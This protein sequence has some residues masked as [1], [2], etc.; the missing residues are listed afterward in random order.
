MATASDLLKQ[1]EAAR[2]KQA[3]LEAVLDAEATCPDGVSGKLF[4][5]YQK[6]PADERW[7]TLRDVQGEITALERLR[8]AAASGELPASD[9]HL[10]SVD[11]RRRA[12]SSGSGSA[13]GVASVASLNVVTDADKSAVGLPD[14]W[15]DDYTGGESLSTQQL[16][17]L[18]Q[19]VIHRAVVCRLGSLPFTPHSPHL[20][21]GSKE[22]V[23][24]FLALVSD[25]ECVDRM[26]WQNVSIFPIMASPDRR[27]DAAV[28]CSR[29]V[30]TSTRVQVAAEFLLLQEF[31]NDEEFR[32]AVRARQ[33][34][35]PLP[36]SGA[37]A[38]RETAAVPAAAVS[39]VAPSASVADFHPDAYT[40]RVFRRRPVI[41]PPLWA[42]FV[43]YF[44]QRVL[45]TSGLRTVHYNPEGLTL[46]SGHTYV[47]LRDDGTSDSSAA[48]SSRG[49]SNVNGVPSVAD[50]LHMGCPS[51]DATSAR[52]A[53]TIVHEFMHFARRCLHAASMSDTAPLV[54]GLRSD[55]DVL[56]PPRQL[57]PP[58]H[59]YGVRPK[60][61]AGQSLEV[62]LIGGVGQVRG[63]DA[64]AKAFLNGGGT[65]DRAWFELETPNNRQAPKK[66][67]VRFTLA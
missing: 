40:Q 66:K 44:M 45:V 8:A 6:M 13:A 59:H 1:L 43:E 14:T 55:G 15:G 39:P 24:L 33:A 53:W 61:E 41:A 19:V 54:I 58:P 4:N 18:L 49:G 60:G 16:R 11:H 62:L 64:A 17:D 28:R 3:A 7:P 10:A 36:L 26:P 20:S 23:N 34:V 21:C 5:R 12:H 25:N 30:L 27:C 63:D 56:L 2:A 52:M 67:T 51:D 37:A 22:Y 35:G 32:R 65:V 42:N 9:L 46:R 29:A 57:S 38:G 48:T 31:G 50:H 47:L